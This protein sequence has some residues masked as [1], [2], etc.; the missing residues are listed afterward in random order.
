M[1]VGG[2]VL[3]L[4][5]GGGI[6]AGWSSLRA[7]PQPALITAT[8]Q[9]P[10]EPTA[11]VSPT[12]ALLTK[13]YI[14]AGG[15]LVAT[16]TQGSNSAQGNGIIAEPPDDPSSQPPPIVY[17]DIAVFR[18]SN[19]TW[20]ILDR[21]NGAS[22]VEQ[23]WGQAGDKP[24]PGDYDGDGKVDFAVFRP[25]EAKW[26]ILRS[27]DG[28]ID[29]P[30]WGLSTDEPVQG[31]YDGDGKT[32]VAV[33]RGNTW[34]IKKSS[35]GALIS[36]QL[37]QDTDLAV[38]G[39]Y[40]GDGKIDLAT[41]RPS[42]ATWTIMKSSSPEEA[43]ET[44]TVQ[45]GESGDVPQVGDFEGDNITD[46]T[47][48]RLSDAGWR[49]LFSFDSSNFGQTWGLS[50]DVP[51][52]G[53]YDGDGKTDI[54][55]VRPRVSETDNHST[56]YILQSSDGTLMQAQWGAD[57]DIAV[58]GKYNRIPEPACTGNNCVS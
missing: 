3:C 39:D 8:S 18:P 6:V 30:P 24:V 37:G 53:D 55:V 26:Y 42:D 43:P 10:G 58:P 46:F 19:G 35:D 2:L 17:T 45:W 13:D 47:T 56:W 11:V 15:R 5:I 50:T 1:M 40:D 48:F 41:F 21:S 29:A 36:G 16:E 27:S 4:F 14:Y 12:P 28:G 52:P 51:A 22:L 23:M 25:S 44:I 33:R 9:S 20:Y 49:I 31:D 57:G 7:T 34:Y 38:P 54:A 32:D